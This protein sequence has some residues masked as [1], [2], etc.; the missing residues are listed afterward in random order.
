M[1]DITVYFDATCGYYIDPLLEPEHFSAH[2]DHILIL[3]DP[4]SAKPELN[5]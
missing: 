2:R 4:D 5:P 1:S 3:S